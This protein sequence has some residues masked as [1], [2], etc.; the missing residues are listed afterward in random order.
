[1]SSLPLPLPL[2][3]PSSSSSFS[4][5]TLH[6]IVKGLRSQPTSEGRAKFASEAVDACHVEMA[7]T[8]GDVKTQALDKLA[9]LRMLGF[10]QH[11]Q[12]D[13]DTC[14]HAIEAMALPAFRHKR[15]ACLAASRLLSSDSPVLLLLTNSL[16]KELHHRE[17]YVV[18]LA[19]SSLACFCSKDLAHQ[20]LPDVCETLQATRPYVR[21]RGTLA[22]YRMCLRDPEGLIT[23]YDPLRSKLED[24]DPGVISCAVNAIC[25]LSRTTQAHNILPLTPILFK[26]LTTSGNNWMLIKIVKLYCAL[27]SEEPRLAKKLLE[28]LAHIIRTTSA[29]SLLYECIATATKAMKLVKRDAVVDNLLNLCALQLREFIQDPDQNLKY[30]GL[31]G[32]CELTRTVPTIAADHRDLILLCLNDDDITVRLRALELLS[33]MTTSQSVTGIVNKL[34]NHLRDAPP[35]K[36]RDAVVKAIVNCCIHDEGDDEKRF[37]KVPNLK[38]FIAVLFDLAG[39]K[40]IGHGDLLS[41]HLVDVALRVPSMA[42]FCSKMASE[43][44]IS[45]CISKSNTTSSSSSSSSDTVIVA[46]SNEFLGAC[47]FVSCEFITNE[48]ISEESEAGATTTAATTI[49]VTNIVRQLIHSILQSEQVCN[50]VRYGIMDSRTQLLFLHNVVKLVRMGTNGGEYYQLVVDSLLDCIS[51]SG[52]VGQF[53]SERVKEKA[54]MLHGLLVIGQQKQQQQQQQQQQSGTTT[55]NNEKLPNIFLHTTPMIPVDTSAQERLP[56]PSGLDLN[57]SFVGDTTTSPKTLEIDRRPLSFRGR[58]SQMSSTASIVSPSTTT[59]PIRSKHTPHGGILS[60]SN[61]NTAT[62]NN[63]NSL[64]H[65]GP[66]SNHS[67]KK[68]HKKP[69]V[70]GTP[71]DSHNQLETNYISP[72]S[73]PSSDNN[74]TTEDSNFTFKHMSFLNDSSINNGDTNTASSSSSSAKKELMVK[75][76]LPAD[77]VSPDQLN[78]NKKKN[79]IQSE[80]TLKDIDVIGGRMVA[81]SSSQQQQQ[82]SSGSTYKN[83]DPPLHDDHH[84]N[85]LLTSSSKKHHKKKKDASNKKKTKS[86]SNEDDLI[87]FGS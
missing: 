17:P 58:Y 50:W 36:F 48:M 7:S 27:L 76:L 55:N 45:E 31:V 75:P 60:S 32:F 47:A 11:N 62:T 73:S 82:Q 56:I 3:I 30:L 1:M 14:F 37:E 33:G 25:E 15:I 59:Q 52:W 71:K 38:W 72:Q 16:K 53:A 63:N 40:G 54:V 24:P 2:P 69:V 34:L 85:S 39:V 6:D 43:F 67:S 68:S 83:L 87:D 12:G 61:N 26:L 74:T 49:G 9:H 8:D 29:K 78:T 44:L 4:I 81:A 18:G 13:E 80:L 42:S 21:K 77:A 79:N 19:L 5:L 10:D 41:S 35:G 23:A 66:I 86:K 57:I 65:L 70:D 22:L 20:L 28:P 64:F 84:D 51:S 46:P